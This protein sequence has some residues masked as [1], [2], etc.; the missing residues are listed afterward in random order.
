MMS[1]RTL[2]SL[3]SNAAIMRRTLTAGAGV[4]RRRRILLIMAALGCFFGGTAISAVSKPKKQEK[5][6]V[7]LFV[8][9]QGEKSGYMDKTG[10]MVIKLQFYGANDFSEGLAC[11]CMRDCKS[12][13]IDKTGK[14]VIAPQFDSA[15]DFSEGLA[16]VSILNK[17]GYFDKTGYIDKTG[18]MVIEP[19]A[20]SLSRNFSEGLAGVCIRDG[21][22]G[23]IDKTGKM[24]IE[25]QFDGVNDFSEGLASVRIGDKLGYID[26]T[27]KMV[28]EPQRFTSGIFSEGLAGVYSVDKSGYMDKTG[29]MVIEPQFDG[30][31]GFSEGLACVRIGGKSGYINKTGKMVIEPQ[32]DQAY[33]FSEGLACVEIGNKYGYIDKTGRMVIKPQFDSAQVGVF[34]HGLAQVVLRGNYVYIDRSGRVIV[35]KTSNTVTATAKPTAKPK[36]P[37]EVKQTYPAPGSEWKIVKNGVT[38][39]MQFKN[40][41]K[42]NWFYASPGSTVNLRGNS[43]EIGNTGD[44]PARVSAAIHWWTK[45][46]AKLLFNPCFEDMSAWAHRT[47]A[48]GDGTANLLWLDASA[49]TVSGDILPGNHY[50]ALPLSAQAFDNY[51]RPARPKFYLGDGS[52]S[53]GTD[54]HLVVPSSA[55]SG[56][57]YAVYCTIKGSSWSYTF[58]ARFKVFVR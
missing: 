52:Y 34:S 9:R 25:P 4:Q 11:V 12:G 1:H 37:T 41:Q 45:P 23:Y 44:D 22:A 24:V 35:P 53:P 8:L 2:S 54:L 30:A 7:E 42:A 43:L 14:M 56:T 38:Y 50:T 40:L 55:K 29:K 18:K 27:G 10:K 28:I 19:Q 39:A 58:P 49:I 48:G 26:K 32:F 33:D 5:A 36:P 6:P 57:I 13:Y 51:G 16:N 17:S 46:A 31:S 3:V 20:Y 21:K 15:G 47:D